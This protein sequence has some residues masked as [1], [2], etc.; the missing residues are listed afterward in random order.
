[1]FRDSAMVADPETPDRIIVFVGDSS[2]GD[3]SEGG[4]FYHL[5]EAGITAV[6]GIH[7]HCY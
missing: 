4:G 7:G 2:W 3:T 1:M 6:F 5:A